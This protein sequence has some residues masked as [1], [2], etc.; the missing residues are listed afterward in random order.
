MRR[1]AFIFA[2]LIAVFGIGTA[3]AWAAGPPCSS[4]CENATLAVGSTIGTTGFPT[5]ISLAGSA[6][7]TASGVAT[8]Y[9]VFSNTNWTLSWQATPDDVIGSLPGSPA[10]WHT[11]PDTTTGWFNIANSTSITHHG[12]TFL[13][14][15]GSNNDGLS[16][17]QIDTGVATG[18]GQGFADGLSVA[19]PATAPPGQY[20]AVFQYVLAAA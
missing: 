1:I 9:S 18:G 11:G 13:L 2:S 20:Q 19:I 16:P 17:V 15:P 10:T 4:N 14:P 8:P 5:S 12:N 6:G 3:P 7:S